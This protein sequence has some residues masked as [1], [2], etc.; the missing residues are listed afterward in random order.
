MRFSA[1]RQTI[2]E[3]TIKRNK[4]VA[5]YILKENYGNAWVPKAIGVSAYKFNR[6]P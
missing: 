3:R 4:T 1:W 5:I 2:L 6:L